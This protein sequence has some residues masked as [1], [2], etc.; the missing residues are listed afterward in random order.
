MVKYPA[1]SARHRAINK[2]AG[3]SIEPPKAGTMQNLKASK[4]LPSM[5]AEVCPWKIALI[6]PTNTT[7]VTIWR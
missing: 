3:P 2:P 7:S 5:V 6:N 4:K 1:G